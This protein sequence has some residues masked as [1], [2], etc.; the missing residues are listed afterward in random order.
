MVLINRQT[1]LP[2]SR[3]LLQLLIHYFLI[4]LVLGRVVEAASL[5][6]SLCLHRPSPP[7]HRLHNLGSSSA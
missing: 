1:H 3:R 5:P 2:P 7:P 4:A 6:L